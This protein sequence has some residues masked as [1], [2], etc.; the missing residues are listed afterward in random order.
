MIRSVSS[1]NKNLFKLTPYSWDTD[2]KKSWIDQHQSWQ[3]NI[4]RPSDPKCQGVIVIMGERLGLPLED[5]LNLNELLTN[6]NEWTEP[7]HKYKLQYPWPKDDHDLAEQYVKEG[8]FPL[9]GTVFEFLDAFSSPKNNALFMLLGDGDVSPKYREAVTLNNESLYTYINKKYSKSEE[10]DKQQEEKKE[11]FLQREMVR[12]FLCAFHLN[13]QTSQ[14]H[15]TNSQEIIDK[16]RKWITEKV[17]DLPDYKVN[18]Y[19]YLECYD[20]GDRHN[21][22]G[23][24]GHYKTIVDELEK[25]L[26]SKAVNAARITGE[27]GSGKSSVLRAGVM[28]SFQVSDYRNKYK[29]VYFRPTDFSFKEDDR[30]PL[31]LKNDLLGLM[32]KSIGHTFSNADVNKISKH[33]GKAWARHAL[34]YVQQ[35][36]QGK[37]LIVGIDQFEE[38]VDYLT[39]EQYSSNWRPLI[40]FMELA[41]QNNSFAIVYT[42]ESS[43]EDAFNRLIKEHK[44]PVSFLNHHKEPI[45]LTQKFLL[46]IIAEPFRKKGYALSPKLFEKIVSNINQPLPSQNKLTSSSTLPL[47]SLLLSNLYDYVKKEI[48]PV[49]S[50]EKDTSSTFDQNA[51][52]EKAESEG[53]VYLNDTTKKLIELREVINQQA[54]KAWQMAGVDFKQD[55]ASIDKFLQ[56][57]V[58]L[59]ASSTD[60]LQLVPVSSKRYPDEEKLVESFKKHRL[61][62]PSKKGLRLVH[63][64]VVRFWDNA[65]DWLKKRKNYFI[66]ELKLRL[67]ARQWDKAGR[68]IDS[69]FNETEIDFSVEVLSTYFRDWANPDF[70]AS[71]D[72]E[73]LKAY[74]MLIFSTSKTPLKKF[75]TLAGVESPYVC[76][77]ALYGMNGL[78]AKYKKIDAK[79]LWAES[80]SG[81]SPISQASWYRPNTVKYLL[82]NGVK[83]ERKP[84]RLPIIHASI[85]TNNEEVFKSLL[86]IIPPEEMIGPQKVNMLHY[87]AEYNRPKMALILINHGMNPKDRDYKNWTPL[88]Y[89]SWHGQIEAFSFFTTHCDIQETANGNTVLHLAV[90]NGQLNLVKKIIADYDLPKL[91]EATNSSG[92]TALHMAVVYL[93]AQIVNV[94]LDVSDVNNLRTKEESSIIAEV[95]KNPTQEALKDL[96]NHFYK[97]G[98]DEKH[99]IFLMHRLQKLGSESFAEELKDGFKE[100]LTTSMYETPLH[101]LI[102]KLS[103]DELD[104][105]K[106]NQTLKLLLKIRSLD[107]NILDHNN[108]SALAIAHRFKNV[109]VQKELLRAKG[110]PYNPNQK[111]NNSGLTAAIV[112]YTIEDWE[113]FQNFED[114]TSLFNTESLDEDVN[115]AFHYLCKFQNPPS[116]II[117]LVFSEVD[118]NFVNGMNRAGKTP[119]I[120]SIE[121]KKW[122]LVRRFIDDLDANPLIHGKE[123]K[124]TIF[125]LLEDP[126]VDQNLVEDLLN[127]DKTQLRLQDYCGWNLLHRSILLR[128]TTW[129]DRLK[130]E[131]VFEELFNTQDYLG[132]TPE[133]IL[134]SDSGEELKI[135]TKSTFQKAPLNWDSHLQWKPLTSKQEEKLFASLSKKDREIDIEGQ[136]TV[137]KT[138]LPFYKKKGVNL[139]RIRKYDRNL[140][141]I[142]NK[143]NLVILNGKS[144]DIHRLNK[145]IPI[146][147]TSENVLDYLRFFCFF[148]RGKEGP[149]F[150]AEGMDIY[151]IPKELQDDEKEKVAKFLRPAQLTR[152]NIRE[153]FY[154]VVATVFYSDAIFYSDFKVYNSGMVEMLHDTPVISNL[155]KKIYSPII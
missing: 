154:F 7:N 141:V 42:L 125:L 48:D 132:F 81:R 109:K 87:C 89:A 15:S 96:I 46:E 136:Q 70:K 25:R 58:G 20:V 65:D 100:S 114:K 126:N 77:A 59:T 1:D 146:S 82:E 22:L 34:D 52:N 91:W 98:V 35:K 133:H 112:S 56:P 97:N 8:K 94:L 9:T 104:Q 127:K 44:I 5:G 102:K 69:D 32:E 31:N 12:N 29:C 49:L 119:L 118:K 41:S 111:I 105:E 140:Y 149:F 106:F 153:G 137:E 150:I 93:S 122:N 66:Q 148:V 90:A 144:E 115:N 23:R 110:V 60:Q 4:P 16:A 30:T 152:I 39:D 84:D 40:D 121:S 129:I 74:V 68:L 51:G 155:S 83:V 2:A 21:F 92:N 147:L 43:R 33:R 27:S 75:T 53:F 50:S 134:D 71:N 120:L 61:I 95:L 18:P 11:Y 54:T 24:H 26:Y 99:C 47:I 17:Y 116:H 138:T 28:D 64:A 117:D 123:Q 128:K 45:E 139:I 103:D 85:Q 78:L 67:E 142:E 108:E 113:V 57:F 19:K 135:E 101:L 14:N 72:D 86:N 151:D 3:K 38:I 73:I 63:E 107:P 76:L 13:K 131:R 6:I 80:S 55:L 130:N 37:I 10:N 36:L 79:S 124:P 143:N 88:H 62:V 145:L